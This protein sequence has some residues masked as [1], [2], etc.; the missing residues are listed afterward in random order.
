MKTKKHIEFLRSL[1]ACSTAIEFAETQ[2]SFED[3]IKN[4]PRGEWLLWLAQKMN[5]DLRLLT[6]AKGKCAETVIHLMKDERSINA[7]KVA[8][9]FGEGK[10]T[11]EEL[12]AYAYASAASAAAAAAFAVAYAFADSADSADAKEKNRL[13]TAEICRD[14]LSTFLIEKYKSYN[15]GK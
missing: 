7:V 11:L 6:L 4:C 12:K 3:A 10:S 15:Y 9:D 5:C 1:K 8:I 13:K 14:S 2:Y